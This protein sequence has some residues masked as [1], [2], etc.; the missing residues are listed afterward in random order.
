MKTLLIILMLGARVAYSQVNIFININGGVVSTVTINT[1]TNA[2]VPPVTNNTVFAAS[3]SFIDVSNAVSQAQLGWTVQLPCG[4]NGW[5]NQ[6]V[7]MGVTLKGSGTNCTVISDETPV[8]GGGSGSGTPF[9][10]LSLTNNFTTRVSGIRFKAGVTNNIKT[11]PNNFGGN[12]QVNGSTPNYRIDN[13][14]FE[15]L[16]GKTIRQTGDTFGLIDHDSFSTSN[17][18]SV[19]V[20][21]NGYGDSDWASAITLGSSNSTYIENCD[22]KDD[23]DF[24]WVDISAGGRLVFRYNTSDGFYINTHGTEST[25]RY[26]SARYIEV[27]ENVLTHSRDIA[28]GG[29]NNFYTGIDIRGGSAIVFSNVFYAVNA[30]T[31]MR[32]YRSTDNSPVFSP[33]W[34]ATGL[35]NWDNNGSEIA[36]GTAAGVTNNTILTVTNASWTPSAFIGATVYNYQSN[37]CGNVTA[38]TATTMTFNNN[39]QALY[40]IGF[41]NGNTFSVHKIYPML[42]SVGVGQGNLL[43]GDVPAP[44]N[45]NQGVQIL[46]QW[47]NVRYR[48]ENALTLESSNA[49]TAYPC[50]VEGR[51]FT[52]TVIGTYTPFTYPHP[53]IN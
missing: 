5:W 37:R 29:F 12:I 45:L 32:Y 17:R 15:L 28:A 42:D 34:G 16:S 53:S 3:T 23:N 36:S 26:R 20:F 22:F 33:F 18:I 21:G 19:E 14:R 50:I 24:G 9:L 6:L 52:N 40:Q 13:C 46:G 44:V 8:V 43:S 48:M 49:V 41:T 2:P 25:G 47:K 30:T 31:L 1:K 27:Y 39:G 35:T 10:L 7:L 38:N 4:T 51:D 11:F